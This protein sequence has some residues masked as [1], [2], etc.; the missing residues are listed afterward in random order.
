MK[1]I[2]QIA[3]IA[4]L[5]LPGLAATTIGASAMP[6]ASPAPAS[7]PLVQQVAWGCGPGWRPNIWGRC[8]PQYPVY[9]YGSYGWS[10]PVYYYGWGG[11]WH[12]P[13]Y[14][15]PWHRW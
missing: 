1:R 5:G 8:V 14:R 15:H 6:L 7:A 4:S 2:I 12:R 9:S 3:A 10:R 13:Y 11:G